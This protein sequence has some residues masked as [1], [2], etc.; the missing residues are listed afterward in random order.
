MKFLSEQFQA[1]KTIL[2]NPNIAD[3]INRLVFD[4]QIVKLDN[5]LF[6][7]LNGAIHI[8]FYYPFSQKFN[9]STDL[10]Y[11]FVDYHL[12]KKIYTF[13]EAHSRTPN[14]PGPTWD[15]PPHVVPV[16]DFDKLKSV[17]FILKTVD[18]N[19]SG[20]VKPNVATNTEGK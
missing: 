8:N 1:L 4:D 11:V 13:Q 12:E 16:K 19:I 2:R 9:A 5:K 14:S 17:L 18:F 15:L 10:Q 3:V 7:E 6:V 20:R